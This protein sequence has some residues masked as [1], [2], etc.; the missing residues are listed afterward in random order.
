MTCTCLR[1]RWTSIEERSKCQYIHKKATKLFCR[2]SYTDFALRQALEGYNLYP[3][4]V[5]TYDNSCQWT[6]KMESRF[7]KSPFLRDRLNTAK[8]IIYK[9]PKL[10]SHGHVD[11]CKY[12]N[13]IDYAENV[14]RTHGERIESG[15]SRGNQAGRATCE[16]TASRR[17]EFL[18]DDFNEANYQ[19][20]LKLSK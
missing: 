9:N 11:D 4:I 16:M 14:G 3:H 8:S 12:L 10:H 2:F 18:S 15:W 13:S 19:Q 6:K 17:R 7:Q 5:C 1:L 20:I